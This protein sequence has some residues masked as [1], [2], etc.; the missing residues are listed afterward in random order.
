MNS[1]PTIEGVVAAGFEPVRRAFADNFTERGEI[2]ASVAAWV[3]GEK[4]VDLWAGTATVDTATPW[5]ADTTSVMFS[6]TKGLVATAFLMLE[7]RGQIDLDQRV[8]WYWPEFA[9]AGKQ[10]ITVRSILNHRAGLS[11][12]D[13]P[14][15]LEDFEDFRSVEAALVAQEPTWRPGSRQAYGATAFGMYTQAM[16]RRI[17][18]ETLGSFLKREVFQPLGADLHL[19]L[20]QGQQGGVAHLYPVD[21]KELLRVVLPKVVRN[22]T[23]E[24]RVYRQVLF[25]RGS[26]PSRALTN[27]NMG[28]KRLDRMNEARILELE[29]PW[30]NA[31]GNARSLGR[32]YAALANGGELDG[33]RLVSPEAIERVKPRQSWAYEDGT[34]LKPMGFSQGFVKDEP[35]LFSPN[36][37][38]FCHP[39]AGGS[40]GLADP[41]HRL[42]L[43]Y[44]M[45]RM[46]HHVRSPNAIALCHAM[47]RCLQDV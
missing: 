11:V 28:R 1:G 46:N 6:A 15:E 30:M 25:E 16:F 27:P 20:P 38:A 36:E 41:T 7:D 18:G 31:V 12:I 8:G 35:H 39:G 10:D 33:V 32:V 2:G 19:G 29:L 45:N 21:S 13:R 3:A 44:V 26:I 34:L 24:G 4:V 14:L 23:L 43:A 37:A 42:G 17:T 40:I 22:K 5:T 9:R 47:Y